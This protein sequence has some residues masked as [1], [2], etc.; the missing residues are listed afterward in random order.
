MVRFYYNILSGKQSL[1]PIKNSNNS[2][3]PSIFQSHLTQKHSFII[4]ISLSFQ[5]ITATHSSVS[6]D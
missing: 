4:L 3:F 5:T 2:Y 6:F 1:F